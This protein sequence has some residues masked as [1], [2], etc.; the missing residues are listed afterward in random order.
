MAIQ[1]LSKLKTYF[2]TGAFPSQ[3]QF[4]DVLD[5]FRHK[6]DKVDIS[7]V[8]GLSTQLNDKVSASA[9]NNEAQTR[10][11]ADTNLQQSISDEA[12]ARE[13]LSS[14]VAA[15]LLNATSDGNTLK[16]L[17]DLIASKA[18]TGYV[19]QKIADLVASAP[20]A[21]DTLNELAAALGNDANFST[22][23][24]NALA[25][26][27]NLADLL[28]KVG[29]QTKAVDG[30]LT[31]DFSKHYQLINVTG[32]TDSISGSTFTNLPVTLATELNAFNRELSII[33]NRST[34]LPIVPR[35]ADLVVGGITYSFLNIGSASISVPAV[36]RIE[37]HYKFIF[38]SQTTCTVSLIYQIQA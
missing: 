36:K 13:G 12:T 24:I 11:E 34:A 22:T 32:G 19:D 8:D 26:K 16:K 21:L 10:A 28:E 1:I 15:I 23:V 5:S 6:S 27:A 31:L 18:S 35:T 7:D 38:T 9:I 20:A 37:M 33:N 17:Y 14:Q 4:W 3:E 29:L 2:Y 30:A 25:G